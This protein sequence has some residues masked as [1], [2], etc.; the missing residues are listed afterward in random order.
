MNIGTGRHSFVELLDLTVTCD[1]CG[2][3]GAPL[4]IAYGYPTLDTAELARQEIVML[5]G[6]LVGEGDPEAVCRR[7]QRPLRQLVEAETR[8]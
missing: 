5:G 2:F 1:R 8:E 7:C 6:C 3:R 4:P